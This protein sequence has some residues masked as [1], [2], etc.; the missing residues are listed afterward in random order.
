MP[1]MS[2]VTIPQNWKP[3]NTYHSIAM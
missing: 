2:I 3:L 1:W